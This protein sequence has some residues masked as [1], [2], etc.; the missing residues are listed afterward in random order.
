M[1]LSTKVENNITKKHQNPQR[2]FLDVFWLKQ[3]IRTKAKMKTKHETP[4]PIHTKYDSRHKSAQRTLDT[5]VRTLQPKITHKLAFNKL[6]TMKNQ[7]MFMMYKIILYYLEHGL[8][9][10]V[11]AW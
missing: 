9:K 3:D 6:L 10:P 2:T 11:D 5:R 1:K 8:D 4:Q 7:E